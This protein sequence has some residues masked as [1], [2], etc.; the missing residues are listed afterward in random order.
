MTNSEYRLKGPYVI[1]SFLLLRFCVLCGVIVNSVLKSRFSII[2]APGFRKRQKQRT[3]LARRSS[4]ENYYSSGRNT[5]FDLHI[6]AGMGF[7]Q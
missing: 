3:N 2:S 4:P 6:S 1:L 7:R 5:D